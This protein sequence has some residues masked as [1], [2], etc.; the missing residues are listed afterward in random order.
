MCRPSWVIE[1]L[2]VVIG[3]RPVHWIELSERF[4]LRRHVGKAADPIDRVAAFENPDPIIWPRKLR[5]SPGAERLV[6][7][8]ALRPN[9]RREHILHGLAGSVRS[10]PWSNRAY[11]DRR[12]GMRG[13]FWS[14]TRPS[15]YKSRE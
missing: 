10:N 6:A 11:A 14:F 2:T 1:L 5:V 8:E 12:A 7:R 15:D 4:D 13:R 9:L 3:C